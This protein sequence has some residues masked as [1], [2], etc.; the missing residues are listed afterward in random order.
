MF[1]LDSTEKKIESLQRQMGKW[2]EEVETFAPKIREIE[3]VMRERE[4]QIEETKDKMNTVEDRIFAR[5]CEQIGVANIRQ[6]EERELKTQ[7]DRA[8]KKM[9]FDNQINRIGTQLEYERK[10][11]D[12]LRSNVEKFERTVQDDEDSLETAKKVNFIFSCI[13]HKVSH[14]YFFRLSK[15]KCLKLTKTCVKL[16]R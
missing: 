12:Q 7:Q 11:E 9:E 15:P 10:R 2:R 5:F 6:Y 16:T 4:T 8:K 14:E 3:S 1:N 13:I